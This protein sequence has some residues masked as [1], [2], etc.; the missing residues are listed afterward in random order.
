MSEELAVDSALSAQELVTRFQAQTIAHPILR[1]VDEIARQA[2]TAPD[3][4]NLSI[5]YGPTGVGKTTL[6]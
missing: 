5:I 4:T 6:I 1:R 3:S 2:I